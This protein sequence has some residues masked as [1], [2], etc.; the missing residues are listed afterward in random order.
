M[1]SIALPYV[2]AF[3]SLA[4]YDFPV[5]RIGIAGRKAPRNKVSS[6]DPLN[7]V[8]EVQV[9]QRFVDVI[10]DAVFDEHPGGPRLAATDFVSVSGLKIKL[11]F[12]PCHL[13]SPT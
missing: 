8:G 10:R 9:N 2:I 3:L 11:S 5:R 7:H 6:L 1:G 12:G 13:V 4:G